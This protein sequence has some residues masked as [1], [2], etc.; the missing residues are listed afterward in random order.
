LRLKPWNY[1]S[2]NKFKFNKNLRIIKQ[3]YIYKF[4]RNFKFIKFIKSCS[5]KN[6]L[7]NEIEYFPSK[8]IKYFE[9]LNSFYSLQNI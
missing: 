1:L 7:K 8:G 3:K 9:S 2:Q 6:K 5:L 4:Y